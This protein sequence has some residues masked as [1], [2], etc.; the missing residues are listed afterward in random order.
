MLLVATWGAF[1]LLAPPSNAQIT[2]GGIAGKIIDEKGSP[3]PGVVVTARNAETGLEREV[4]SGRDGQY[5]IPGLPPS[6]YAVRASL[7]GYS[8]PIENVIV[9]LGQ[10]VPLNI[11]M[12]PGAVLQESVKVTAESFLL[13]TR[14]T[15]LSTVVTETQIRSYPLINRDYNDLARFAP[16]VKQAPGGQFDPTKKPGIYTPFTTGGTAGRNVNISIDGAD[17]ND[18]VV[19]FFVQGYS[20]EAIQEFEVIQDQYRPEYGRSLGGVVNVITKSGSDT[21]HGSLFGTFRN[22]NTRARNFS[23]DLNGKEK[24]PSQRDAEG[25]SLGGPL[26]KDRLF[27]FI[28]WERQAENNPSTLNSLLTGFAG[29]EPPGFPFRIAGPGTSV[30]RNLDRDLLTARIDWQIS[31][32]HLL[33]LRWA[34]DH[35][36]FSNDQGGPLTD[37]SNDGSSTNRIW[38]AVANWQWIIGS[39]MMNELKVHRNDFVNRINSAS[40][41]PLLT[42]VYDSFSLGRNFNTPQ[43]TFQKKMQIRDDFTWIVDRHSLKAGVERIGV[44][45]P[46]SNFGPATYPTVMF[47][48]NSG[49]TPAGS[50]VAGDTN[51]NGVN[52]G[53]EAIQTVNLITPQLNP[54]TKYAQLSAYLQDEWSVAARWRIGLGLRGDLDQGIFRDATR[55]INRQLYECFAHPEDAHQCG[56]DPATP[57]PSNPPAEFKPFHRTFPGDQTN[58][59]PRLGLTY[60]VHGTGRDVLRGSWGLYYDKLL[61]NWVVFMRQNLSPFFSPS[62]PALQ[63]CNT[64]SDPSCTGTQLRAGASPVPGYAPLPADFTLANWTNPASGLRT[65]LTDLTAIQGHATFND[66]VI[67]PSP[68]W[69]TPYTS[70]FSL[71]WGHVISPRLTLDT[72]FIYRQGYRQV[73]NQVFGGLSSG[74]QAPFPVVVDPV[75]GT[76]S[77]PGSVSIFL[78]NGKSRD[79]SLQSSFKGHFEHLDF[80]VNLNVS[81]ATGT[82]DM[83]GTYSSSYGGANDLFQGGNIKYTGGDINAEWGR[84]SGD[85][86]VY[87]FLY[88]IYRFPRGIESSTQITYGSRTAFNGYAGVD[89]NGDGF[90]STEEYA[91]KRGSGRGGDLFNVD[92]RGTKRFA[93]GKGSR[94][95]IFLEVFNLL[96]RANYGIYVGHRQLG[97][98]S[99]VF[100]PNPTYERPI[101]DTI[102]PPR[103][104]QVGFRFAF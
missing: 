84:I 32:Y 92:W 64:A 103:T 52:D 77:Y 26:V 14:K 48:F 60:D 88:G 49:V 99:G 53:I 8:A 35:A 70:S 34:Q 98:V 91:G 31:P 13:N 45:L 4:T 85:Q 72:N 44:D 40:P 42:L 73:T 3:L 11:A 33:W 61:D 65:W 6:A 94:A 2:T 21:L 101:G 18:N 38:S 23:E 62:L 95:E 102:T 80:G 89:L 46:D 20:A 41:D 30:I 87:A 75:S 24:S 7:A 29:T 97:N 59:A 36:D 74:R 17:N 104:T 1:S 56:L 47:Q 9:N 58:L 86:L 68:D 5:A 69:K 39:R 57:N 16:G 19:G 96:N 50:M 43:A 78:S 93:V 12:Q 82:Q 10:T 27:Y 51:G 83:G 76:A 67:M 63:G 54:G 66:A 22:E 71:G 79:V 100:L 37:P 55:G 81:R 15:E 25:F 28:A 90:N